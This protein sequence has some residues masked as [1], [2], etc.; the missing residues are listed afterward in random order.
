MSEVNN[1]ALHESG[2][3]VAHI[4]LGIA[5]M[6]VSIV[7]RNGMFGSVTAEGLDHVWSKQQAEDQVIAYLAG[8]AAVLVSTRSAKDARA[9]TG[10]DFENARTLIKRWRLGPLSAHRDLALKL[11]RKPQNQRAVKRLAVELLDRRSID[12]D[13]AAVIVELADGLATD[14]D[15]RRYLRLRDL[16]APRGSR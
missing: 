1:T 16:G 8:W 11:M 15:Y 14:L 4:R 9:G 6:D 12:A 13:H 10:D 2:H 3:A 7:P 5:Q